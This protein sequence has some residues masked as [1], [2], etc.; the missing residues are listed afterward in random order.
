[1]KRDEVRHASENWRSEDVFYDREVEAVCSMLR[2]GQ[3]LSIA[4]PRR[5]D[6]PDA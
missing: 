5:E 4:A 1:V 2:A 3:G 6:L